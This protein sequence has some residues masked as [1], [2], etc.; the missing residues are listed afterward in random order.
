MSEVPKAQVN[1]TL[2]PQSEG[3]LGATLW[4]QGNMNHPQVVL[5]LRKGGFWVGFLTFLLSR[6]GLKRF[7]N[8]SQ[9]KALALE[10]RALPTDA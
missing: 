1:V 8:I 9:N 3:G 10:L 7:E 6:E 5:P 2:F 4:S